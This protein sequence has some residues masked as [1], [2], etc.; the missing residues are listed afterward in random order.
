M[1]RVRAPTTQGKVERWHGSIRREA[2]LPETAYTEEY[3]ALMERYVRFYNE[4]RPHWALNLETP[5]KVF[6]TH[7]KYADHAPT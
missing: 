1:G 4:E 6:A 5:W 3:L 7:A 2:G